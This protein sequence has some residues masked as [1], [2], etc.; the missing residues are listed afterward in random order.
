MYYVKSRAPHG[1][2]GLK[3]LFILLLADREES[4]PARGARIEIIPHYGTRQKI[5]VAPR[6]GRED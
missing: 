6:T 5:A 1:A 2:R 3:L 4:R